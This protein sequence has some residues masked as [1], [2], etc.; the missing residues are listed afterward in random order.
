MKEPSR[1][2]LLDPD[3]V[4]R[5]ETLGLLAR[6]V[7]EGYRVGEHHSPLQGFAIEFAQHREYTIGDDTRHLDWKVLGRTDRYYI[8]QYDQD[9][10]FVAHILVDGSE[11]MNYGSGEVTKLHYAKG[12]AACLAYLVLVQQDA[13]ALMVA[14]TE[15]REY[16]PRTDRLTTINHIMDRLA[17]FQATQQTGLRKVFDDL[18]HK[19]KSRGI[20]I[21]ISDLFEDEE[22]LNRGIQQLRFKGNEVIVFHVLDPHELE[23]PF[24]GLVEF[25][26]LEGIP[27]IKVRPAD[28]RK[29][30]LEGI[31]SFIQ[32]VRRICEMAGCHYVNVSTA[33]SLAEVITGYLVFRKKI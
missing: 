7:V 26:G 16:I 21:I 10:N 13:V 9:T 5:G 14:D 8:K 11:S 22:V 3:A 29:S 6:L 15:T 2:N 18:A 24:D 17:K 12:L 31:Q 20:V 25:F 23:F 32:R 30:Y 4:A 28:I 27:M 33:R 19:A 1:N